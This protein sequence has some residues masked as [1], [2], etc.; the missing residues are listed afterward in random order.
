MERFT[1]H[2]IKDLYLSILF[3]GLTFFLPEPLLAQPPTTEEN[4]EKKDAEDFV[5]LGYI[6][7]SKKFTLASNGKS[8]TYK[9]R[10]NTTRSISNL[11]A[12]IYE[13]E[14]KK[15]NKSPLYRLVNNPNKGG[16]PIKGS[17][18]SPGETTDWRFLL[19]AAVKTKKDIDYA[20]RISHRGIFF[21]NMET[22]LK[23]SKK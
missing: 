20:L 8:I 16:L 19:T 17:A 11:F 15:D 7:V 23:N 6:S 9:I 5:N 21:V 4:S 14:K 2:I 1:R 18:H 10:N 13:I 22:G 12:W 3:T